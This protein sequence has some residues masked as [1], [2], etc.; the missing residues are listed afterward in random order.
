MN[1]P[2]KQLLRLVKAKKLNH[3]GNPVMKWM[4]D[5]MVVTTDANHNIRPNKEIQ[6]QN[7]RIVALIY[8]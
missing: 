5:D 2:T 8:Y 3:G 1:E 7:R 4:V 6:P